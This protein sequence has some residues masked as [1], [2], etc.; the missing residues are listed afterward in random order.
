[1]DPGG[2]PGRREAAPGF[3][4]GLRSRAD[5]YVHCISSLCFVPVHY[6]FFCV[7]ALLPFCIP[8]L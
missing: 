3:A 6:L 5:V 1:M 4:L 2:V 8:L 7:D